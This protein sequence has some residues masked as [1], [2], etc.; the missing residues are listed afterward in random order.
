M[1]DYTRNPDELYEPQAPAKTKPMERN[2]TAQEVTEAL[3]SVEIASLADEYDN[4]RSQSSKDSSDFK[5]KPKQGAWF[6]YICKREEI[7]PGMLAICQKKDN[8]VGIF[9]FGG[10]EFIFLYT[11]D[12]AKISDTQLHKYMEAIQK[13]GYTEPLTVVPIRDLKIFDDLKADVNIM[14]D[15]PLSNK[16]Q[17]NISN[18]EVT[19]TDLNDKSLE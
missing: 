18:L 3:I 17:I 12:Q 10:K 16:Q 19:S 14:L 8:S 11:N 5:E 9:D 13:A 6:E 4:P 2:P 1:S 15:A 7:Q